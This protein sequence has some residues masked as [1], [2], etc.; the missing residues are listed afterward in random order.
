MQL[1]YMQNNQSRIDY[2]K[3]NKYLYAPFTGINDLT[4]EEQKTIKNFNE[5]RRNSHKEM[6]DKVDL[7]EFW[8]EML[9]ASKELIFNL[10][11]NQIT[12]H[13][14]VCSINIKRGE[15][16]LSELLSE[17]I[18]GTEEEIGES[19]KRTLALA[20]IEQVPIY[21]NTEDLAPLLAKYYQS[22]MMEGFSTSSVSNIKY[23]LARAIGEKIDNIDFQS[24][25]KT[26][27]PV[28]PAELK[29]IQDKVV[30]ELRK[31]NEASRILASLKSAI[32]DLESLLASGE[33]NE[34]ILQKCLTQNPI[35]FGVEY[36]CIKPKQTLGSDYEMDYALE[37]VSGLFDLVE[38]ESSN[39]KL[40]T[41][42]G[43]PRKELVHAEQQIL[44]WLTWIEKHNPY[45]REKLPGITKPRGYVIIGRSKDLSSNDLERLNRRNLLFRDTL[46]IMTYDV[47]LEKAKNLLNILS[48]NHKSFIL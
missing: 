4:E 42:K 20:H 12:I 6:W 21:P 33:R 22:L 41:Q 16:E 48:G 9:K 23:K 30:E 15:I 18:D 24:D 5:K 13:Y 37:R 26:S 34:N 32:D 10:V 40:F 28:Q 46:E 3:G 19:I 1:K 25:I 7:G 44:D 11:D 35:L 17:L 2:W 14:I 38:I 45:I 27:L 47:L 39:L 29:I 43:N 36:V 31:N 8:Y